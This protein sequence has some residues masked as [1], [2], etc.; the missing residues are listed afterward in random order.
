MVLPKSQ[1]KSVHST[2]KMALSHVLSSVYPYTVIPALLLSKYVTATPFKS[3]V[4]AHQKENFF[5]RLKLIY[6]LLNS[7]HKL[8]N[9]RSSRHAYQHISSL[10]IKT[11]F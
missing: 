5:Y 11:I 6:I 1:R 9:Q 4:L 7:V 3:N 2:M 8:I 10:I